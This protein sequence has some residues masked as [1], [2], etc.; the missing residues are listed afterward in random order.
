M[1]KLVSHL[2]FVIL[3]SIAAPAGRISLRAVHDAFSRHHYILFIVVLTIN[4]HPRS[5]IFFR[6]FVGMRRRRNLVL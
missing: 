1:D 3:G 2:C 5:K 6:I 4:G